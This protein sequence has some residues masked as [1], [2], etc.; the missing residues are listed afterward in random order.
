MA[1]LYC[2]LREG[3]SRLWEKVVEAQESSEL[4]MRLVNFSMSLI[5][6]FSAMRKQK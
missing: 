2:R 1:L 6:Y 3:G 4:R 5:F